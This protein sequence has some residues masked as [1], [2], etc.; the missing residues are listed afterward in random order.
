MYAEL[1][2][3]T[4]VERLSRELNITFSNL[5][6]QRQVML[7]GITSD[8]QKWRKKLLKYQLEMEINRF[9]QHTGDN[10]KEMVRQ[11]TTLAQSLNQKSEQEILLNL[12]KV[13]KN[14][15][16]SQGRRLR[17]VLYCKYMNQTFC[18]PMVSVKSIKQDLHASNVNSPLPRDN[19]TL[20]RGNAAS[21]SPLRCSS[22]LRQTDAQSVQLPKLGNINMRQHTYL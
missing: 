10:S 6:K 17:S 3:Q 4:Q 16:V 19:T 13:G 7:Q 20:T 22:R 15:D 18:Q 14:C 1:Q 21:S 9:R 8:Q 11:M 5:D 2:C 12:K